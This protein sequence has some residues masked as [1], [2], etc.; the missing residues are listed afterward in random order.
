MRDVSQLRD[1]EGYW[2][3]RAH[4]YGGTHQ[5]GPYWYGTGK[6]PGGAALSL[7]RELGIVPLSDDMETR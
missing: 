6:T 3:F 4:E 7:A 1:E 5:T 2:S